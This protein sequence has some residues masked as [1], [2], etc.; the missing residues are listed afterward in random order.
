MFSKQDRARHAAPISNLTNLPQGFELYELHPSTALTA[1]AAKASGTS[2]PPLPPR[3]YLPDNLFAP[4]VWKKLIT[5]FGATHSLVSIK[6][7]TDLVDNAI[8]N[9][10]ITVRADA[11]AEEKLFNFIKW[12]AKQKALDG[13]FE[14]VTGMTPET[15]SQ[16]FLKYVPDHLKPK[17][18]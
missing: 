9:R 5:E 10:Y 7:L 4:M 17:G 12:H 16:D 1:A 14:A 11:T 3:D 18:S 8:K 2:R 15:F 13:E 6:W